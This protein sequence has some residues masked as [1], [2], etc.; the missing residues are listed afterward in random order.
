MEPVTGR[1][2]PVELTVAM[3]LFS[4][5][6]LGLRLTAI[7][8]KSAD[9][10]NV[11][12]QSCDRK[13]PRASLLAVSRRAV[14]VLIGTEEPDGVHQERVGGRPATLPG[15]DRGR[16]RQALPVGPPA[17]CVCAAG[18]LGA[19]GDPHKPTDKPTLERF[20]R[21][22]RES[23]LEHLPG[24]KGPD[25]FSRGKRRGEAAFYYVA[26]LEQIIREWVATVYH[27]SAHDGLARPGAPKSQFSPAEMFEVGLARRRLSFFPARAGPGL[28]SSSTW[29]GGLSSTT[30]SRSTGSLRRPGT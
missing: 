24:Y 5:C 14:N 12:Y 6:I 11:L 27:H 15:D 13:R 7:S 17:R 2:L 19:A 10:A 21:T 16:P 29:S 25:V 23:L 18:D 26:E 20:F 3:D 9:V 30:A 1:W 22:L 28:S 8:T 4:R